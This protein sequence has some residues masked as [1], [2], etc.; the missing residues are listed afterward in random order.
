[1]TNIAQID[2]EAETNAVRG[3]LPMRAPSNMFT[4]TISM[5]TSAVESYFDVNE[6]MTGIAQPSH[7]SSVLCVTLTSQPNIADRY[8]MS[9]LTA[10][11][12]KSVGYLDPMNVPVEYL[13]PAR[14]AVLAIPP[15]D[16]PLL[17]GI[18]W[19]GVLEKLSAVALAERFPHAVV[20]K[21]RK[22]INMIGRTVY[23]LPNLSDGTDGDLSLFWRFDSHEASLSFEKDGGVV[24]YAYR[25]GG[26]APWLFEGSSLDA[27]QIQ[28]LIDVLTS[29]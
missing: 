9:E 22:A 28:P 27:L 23:L 25:V 17:T 10:L 7:V 1:M 2:F 13:I 6:P 8:L 16:K 3:W 21:A 15:D 14:H 29:V 12:G 18:G 20:V 4:S 26:E 5:S 24:G 11:V 19:P